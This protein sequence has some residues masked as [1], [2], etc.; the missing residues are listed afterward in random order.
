M[1]GFE[2]T[3][4]W[5][6]FLIVVV[7]MASRRQLTVFH[8]T[9]IYLAFHF[10]VFVVRPSLV[11][12]FEFDSIW[13][14]IGFVPTDTQMALTLYLSS[15]GLIVFCAAFALTSSHPGPKYAEAHRDLTYQEKKAFYMMALV[16][17][18]LGLYSIRAARMDGE[19]INGVFV[20]TGTSG[21]LN[22]LQQVLIPVCLLFIVVNR[23]RLWSFLPLVMFLS[24][25]ATQ[26]WGRWTII[27]T[28]FALI[29]F[30]TWEKRRNLP[31]LKVLLPVPLIA[32]LFANLGLDRSYIRN[33]MEGNHEE[34]R[35]ILDPE[36]DFQERFD[37]MDFANFDYLTFIVAT[38]P[39]R[40]ETYTFGTQ[41]LQIFTEPIPRQIWKSKP[42][43][44]PVSF[45]N[46]N[47]YGNFLGLTPALVGDG[48][49]SGGWIGAMLTMALA[50]TGLGVLYN[51]FIRNQHNVFYCFIYMIAAAVMVQLYR[52]GGISIT[53]FLLFTLVPIFAWMFLCRYVFPDPPEEWSEDDQEPLDE[54]DYEEDDEDHDEWE[55]GDDV[56]DPDGEP[57]E[58][59]I[60]SS[61][62]DRF[63]R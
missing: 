28:F 13:R 31:S 1:I 49:L 60:T 3:I 53:K 57:E 39:E 15:A 22:D 36:R 59:V 27:L 26:G 16:F 11:Y 8:P 61:K 52:D 5:L 18:P 48:W 29:L 54:E 7:V 43:G 23:W 44:P 45:F 2:L 55:D 50:G 47:D 33:I 17:A 10:I 41:Y 14:Y 58:E 12:F 63:T 37:T 25:R 46:L 30:H 9:S 35:N 19:H 6:V 34:A 24:Y 21:Y 20:M 62:N 32:V 40:T 38:V 51:W 4:Q 56:P 42:I